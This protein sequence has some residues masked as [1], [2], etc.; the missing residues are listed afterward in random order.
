MGRDELVDRVRTEQAP[1]VLGKLGS[2]GVQRSA[3]PDV[4][5]KPLR[6]GDQR[7]EKGALRVTRGRSLLVLI[8]HSDAAVGTAVVLSSSATSAAV[9][10]SLR[11]TVGPTVSAT[12]ALARNT[13]GTTLGW[14]L[15]PAIRPAVVLSC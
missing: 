13:A 7:T 1:A 5:R 11:A 3:T 8:R 6:I 2:R 15:G 14:T 9:G 4:G 10:R 12:I